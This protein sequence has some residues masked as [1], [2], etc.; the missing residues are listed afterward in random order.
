M[1]DWYHAN[2][3][4][5][6]RYDGLSQRAAEKHARMMRA[7]RTGRGLFARIPSMPSV[8]L[9]IPDMGSLSTRPARA[10]K[11]YWWVPAGFAAFFLV[12]FIIGG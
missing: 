5:R 8:A 4:A 9:N 7:G 6:T 12:R 11:T 3:A 2:H 10:V 1:S